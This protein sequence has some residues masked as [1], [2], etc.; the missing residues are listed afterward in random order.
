MSKKQRT[1][2]REEIVRENERLRGQLAQ[3]RTSRLS[4]N[5]TAIVK[6]LIKYGS[7]ATAIVMSVRYLAGQKTVVDAAVDLCG[8]FQD[9]LAELVPAWWVQVLTLAIYP[10]FWRAYSRLRR[11]NSEHVQKLSRMTVAHETAVDPNRS[12]SGLGKDGETH[13]RD[14]I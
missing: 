4:S 5:V 1:Q 7:M 8:S 13:E 10:F 9:L 2:T 6:H 3:M 14:Q 12:S 11:I